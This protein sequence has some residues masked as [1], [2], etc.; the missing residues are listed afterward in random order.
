ML[1]LVMIKTLYVIYIQRYSLLRLCFI[2]SE[3]KEILVIDCACTMV[4]P[5]LSQLL[6]HQPESLVNIGSG[7][8][9]A[10]LLDRSAQQFAGPDGG[11]SDLYLFLTFC[12]E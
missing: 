7:H 1:L 9:I 4:W 5:H 3:W 2:S 10:T 6:S 11:G 12:W 8:R